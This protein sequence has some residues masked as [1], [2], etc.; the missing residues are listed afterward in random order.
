MKTFRPRVHATLTALVLAILLPAQALQAQ[1]VSVSPASRTVIVTAGK[2]ATVSI[3]AGSCKPTWSALSNDTNVAT[4]SPATAKAGNKRSFKIGTSKGLNGSSTTVDIT[5]EGVGPSCDL[6][7]V[8]TIQVY[9]VRDANAPK[10]F[11]AFAKKRLKTLKKDSSSI[12]KAVNADLKAIL[13]Q[14][15]TGTLPQPEGPGVKLPAPVLAY[16]L[17]TDC[18]D[19]ALD[20]LEDAYI[21]FVEGLAGDGYSLMSLYG[22]LSFISEFIAAEFQTGSCGV[23]DSA[24]ADGSSTLNQARQKVDGRLKKASSQIMQQSLWTGTPLTINIGN[25]NDE[26]LESTGGV[27]PTTVQKFDAA[28]GKV[29]KIRKTSAT[30]YVDEDGGNDHGRIEVKGKALA[31]GGAVTITYERLDSSGMPIGMDTGDHFQETNV[32]LDSKCKFRG[33]APGIATTANLKPGQWRVTVTQGTGD[34]EQSTTS[35]VTVPTGTQGS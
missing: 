33:R 26:T 6:T 14:L 23:W 28:K 8:V 4:V 10:H 35:T 30:N 1:D 25:S 17:A 31:G 13:K 9:V 24:V 27:E 20:D 7:E 29:F 5:V 3:D 21:N 11:S 15:K 19:E 16:L 18:V 12:D 32:P 34:A 2:S 22:F